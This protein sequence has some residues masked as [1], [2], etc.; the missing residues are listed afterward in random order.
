MSEVNATTPLPLGFL[1]VLLRAG[2]L[3]LN[4]VCFGGLPL[5]VCPW[6]PMGSRLRLTGFCWC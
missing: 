1:L 3:G 4:L 5:S 2:H 6:E